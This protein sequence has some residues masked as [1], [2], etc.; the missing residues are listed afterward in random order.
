MGNV[1]YD[2]P[3]A[4]YAAGLYPD[5]IFRTAP[6]SFF[7][8]TVVFAYGGKDGILQYHRWLAGDGLF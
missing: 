4:G 5:E 8:G 1:V 2:S 6:V 7:I 3:S